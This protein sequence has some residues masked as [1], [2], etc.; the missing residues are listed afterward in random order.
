MKRNAPDGGGEC[1]RTRDSGL[2]QHQ[3]LSGR[4][5]KEEWK[6]GGKITAD[7]LMRS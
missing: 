1:G 6:K 2:L 4:E 3:L 5:E 7:V